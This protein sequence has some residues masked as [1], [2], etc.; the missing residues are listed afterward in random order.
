MTTQRPDETGK[1]SMEFGG[2]LAAMT[3]RSIFTLDPSVRVY[4]YEEPLYDRT[5][6]Q[7]NGQYQHA[8]DEISDFTFS[9]NVTRDSTLTSEL[10]TTGITFVNKPR[11]VLGGDAGYV[12][13]MS[14]RDTLA[15]GANYGEITYSGAEFTGLVDYDYR[16]AYLAWNRNLTERLTLGL[17]T[18][19][20][21]TN[22]PQFGAQDRAVTAQVTGNFAFSETFGTEF[23]IGLSRLDS[24]FGTSGDTRTYDLKFFRQGEHLDWHVGASH[25]LTPSGR[26]VLS[27]QSRI[28]CGL[29]D[30]IS[31]NLRLDAR[32]T[33][34][35][36]EE[37]GS[38]NGTDVRYVRAS[39]NA[40]WRL[41]RTLYLELQ[42]AHAEQQR[43]STADSA[44]GNIYTLGL[45]W[46]GDARPLAG[47]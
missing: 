5:D 1:V 20:A 43:Q 13:R 16:T 28:E 36:T 15:I 47:R 22:A 46:Q 42:I 31:E 9:V 39:L 19:A 3:E 8:I 17:L 38:I 33:G 23:A 6:L 10:G 26:G 12:R 35:E 18:N 40:N 2:S 37:S 25:A 27:R 21:E 45:K 14:E 41:T 24:D 34:I 7:A 4:R 30:Q 44:A 11:T 29:S 32:L